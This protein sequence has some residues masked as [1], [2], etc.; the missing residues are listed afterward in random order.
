MTRPALPPGCRPSAAAASKYVDSEISETRVRPERSA[1]SCHC[2]HQLRERSSLWAADTGDGQVR[3]EI[4]ELLVR[5][6]T[7]EV[8]L[9]G[10]ES[11]SRSATEISNSAAGHVAQMRADEPGNAAESA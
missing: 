10:G 9:S 8:L 7:A 1:T 5:E 11:E 2:A 4:I 6:M 3:A